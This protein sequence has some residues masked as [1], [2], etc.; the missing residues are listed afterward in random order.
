MVFNA[1]GLTKND[2]LKLFPLFPPSHLQTPPAHPRA[3]RQEV[4][5][6]LGPTAKD[7]ANLNNY[8]RRA[9]YCRCCRRRTCFAWV[10]S[11]AHALHPAHAKHCKPLTLHAATC[12][13][14][15]AL[16][17]SITNMRQYEYVQTYARE[18]SAHPRGWSE[19]D[20]EP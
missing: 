3:T 6:R 12:N 7:R 9:C 16:P 8:I 1:A 17:N 4:K 18:G 15:L 13:L 11:A 20:P 5:I 2:S 14:P 19:P 10:P